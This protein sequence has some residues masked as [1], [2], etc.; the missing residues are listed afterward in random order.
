MA[1]SK[2]Y[3]PWAAGSGLVRRQKVVTKD[4]LFRTR[5]LFKILF[6]VAFAAILSLVYIWSRVQ[7]VQYG[8]EIN[9]LRNREQQLTEDNK[10]LKVEV[11]TLS[12][13][14]RL[15]A[16]ATSKLKMQLPTETQIKPLSE[17]VSRGAMSRKAEL[18]EP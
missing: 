10:R 2:I 14:Q 8:Y 1:I 15:Q 12:A 6:V 16:I 18:S 4:D 11:A 13:P 5:L 3:S 17:A 7:I 9:E